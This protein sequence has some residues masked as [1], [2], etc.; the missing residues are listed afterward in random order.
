MVQ[1]PAPQPGQPTTPFRNWFLVGTL[2]VVRGNG[3]LGQWLAK[4][5]ANGWPVSKTE[6]QLKRAE[7]A[8]LGMTEEETRIVSAC[9]AAVEEAVRQVRGF[10]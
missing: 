7:D 4:E 6:G 1:T 2:C 9:L 10:E 5:R 8:V 3:T